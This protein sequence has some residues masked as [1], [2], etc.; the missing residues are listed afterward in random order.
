MTSCSTA[1]LAAAAADLA[2]IAS[3]F[4]QGFCKNVLREMVAFIQSR[5]LEL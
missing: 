5:N 2:F 1:I 4:S 3:R